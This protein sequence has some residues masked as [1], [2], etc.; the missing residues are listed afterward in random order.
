MIKDVIYRCI[1]NDFDEGI[2]ACGYMPLRP[3]CF[4]QRIPG[5]IHTTEVQPDGQWL[6]F[7]I[8][9]GK[10]VYQYM[11]HLKLLPKA[12]V[13]LGGFNITD[14][15]FTDDL[16]FKLKHAG[17]A[18]LP[19]LLSDLTKA[20]L[21]LSQPEVHSG[22]HKKSP[23]Y[24][25]EEAKKILDSDLQAQIALPEIAE[26]LHISYESFRKQF[27]HFTGMSPGSYRRRQRLRQAAL[28]LRSGMSV[29]ETA[30]LTGYA[31]TYAF[32][33]EFKKAMDITPGKYKKDNIYPFKS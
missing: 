21:T 12:P 15:D 31:D 32:T 28:M 25:I 26:Q 2:M 1:G 6:E 27:T 33:R 20:V 4:V 18:E 19:F 3:G 7:F 24:I 13:S 14:R 10:S 17:E 5:R 16:L 30:A 8:S 23:S 11:H 9:F 29:K 22:N